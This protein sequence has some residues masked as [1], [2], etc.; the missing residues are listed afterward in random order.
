VVTV[1][2]ANSPPVT[3]PTTE[4]C[5]TFQGYG[6]G[7]A[8]WPEAILSRLT[9]NQIPVEAGI[10]K[11]SNGKML[12]LSA[13]QLQ[14]DW[15]QELLLIFDERE[16]LTGMLATGKKG[17]T[18]SGLE[19]YRGQFDRLRKAFAQQYQL[20]SQT[21]PYVGDSKASFRS[22]ACSIT[23]EAPHQSFDMTISWR[24]PEFDRQFRAAP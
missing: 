7:R 2:S 9:D 17:G 16:Q 5:A 11:Y 23:L 1:K 14:D 15:A 22:G 4:S 10:N 6:L 8:T 13:S 21:V 18:G 12:R 19:S 20:V 24:T 3:P